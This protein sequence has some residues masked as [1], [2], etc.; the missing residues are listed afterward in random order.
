[1][2]L[3]R[4]ADAQVSVDCN[5]NPSALQ[6]AVASNTPG[7]SFAITGLC[8]GTVS[9]GTSLALLNHLGSD[10]LQT[11]DGIQ[12]EL[13]ITG[14]A[15]VLIDGITLE[16]TASDTGLP[17]IL[18]V[19]GTPT[20]GIENSRIINGQ[21][22][23]L[24]IN[25]G[26]TVVIA[27]TTISGNGIA[28]VAG[29]SDGISAVSAAILLGGTN[30]DGSVDPTQAVTIANNFGNGIGLFGHGHLAMA[31][32]IIQN[33]GGNQAFLAGASDLELVGTQVFQNQ[34]PSMPG[35]FAI[36]ALGGSTVGLFSGS[37]VSGG[38]VA[39]A[40][41]VASAGS[42]FMNGALLANTS[43]SVPTI[44]ISGSS[45]GVL[46]GGNTIQNTQSGGTVLQIDHASSFQQVGL[47]G[48]MPELL[49]GIHIAPAPDSLCFRARAESVRYRHGHDLRQSVFD[50]ERAGWELHSGA[51]E[52]VASPLGRRDDFR[53]GP[54]GL[55]AQRQRGQQHDHDPAG[56][57]RLLQ[58]FPGRVGRDRRRRQCRL[59]LRGHAECA[60]HG[61]SQYLAGGRAA[62]RDRQ[63]RGRAQRDLARLLGA[64]TQTKKL[65]VRNFPGEGKRRR[66]EA[67]PAPPTPCDRSEGGR[68]TDHDH[69]AASTTD[70]AGHKKGTAFPPI[71]SRGP[72]NGGKKDE[73]GAQ[74]HRHSVV[75]FEWTHD[76]RHAN[77][78]FW[79]RACVRKRG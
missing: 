57:E 49:A 77:T 69:V 38:G 21:R 41:L 47:A 28:H 76:D 33:N 1:M 65:C 53:R 8:Q 70:L 72:E 67:A 23:G 64:V 4:T 39:G 51:A 36:Q 15:L 71:G 30:S 74:P 35:A 63:P 34:T 68:L 44:Q 22:M 37:V 20:V 2:A 78:V 9:V 61:Q 43:L 56:I 45:N 10:T 52:L 6:S 79:H 66:H 75:R 24:N 18:E 73:R 29:Q 42:L 48:Y 14:S 32:G 27:N 62:G 60:C 50:V 31:G 19:L 7:T 25:G 26:A 58:S 59:R 16:G 40:V 5:S 46:G 55:C 13:V 17:D 12:G 54:V 11:S 3:G